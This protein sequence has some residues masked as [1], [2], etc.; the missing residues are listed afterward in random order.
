MNI[1]ILMKHDDIESVHKSVSSA[2][3]AADA[4][5]PKMLYWQSIDPGY[6]ADGGMY[7]IQEFE[8]ES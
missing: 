2:M 3:G 1:Y 5:S 8:V 7:T 4:S 6:W